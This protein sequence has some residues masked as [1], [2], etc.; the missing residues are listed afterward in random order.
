[1]IFEKKENIGEAT[2]CIPHYLAGETDMENLFSRPI[3]KT[4]SWYNLKINTSHLVETIRPD[5]KEIKVRDLKNDKVVVEKYGNLIIATG[6][7]ARSISSD[8]ENF[9]KVSNI[10]VISDV[11][12]AKKLKEKLVGEEKLK[13]AIIGAGNIGLETC[14]ALLKLDNSHISIIDKRNQVCSCLDKDMSAYIEKELESQGVSLYLNREVVKFSPD[15]KKL[16]LDNKN[17]ISFDILVIS[18]G[19]MPNVKLAKD[20][21]IKLGKTGG[22]KVNKKFETSIRNIYAVGDVIENFSFIN[23][24]KLLNRNALTSVSNSRTLANILGG[25]KDKNKGTLNIGGSRFARVQYGWV[26]LREKDLRWGYETIRFH[27]S[28]NTD[29]VP[30]DKKLHV[31]VLFNRRKKKILGAQAVGNLGV[32]KFLDV[33][34]GVIVSKN[35]ILNL[36]NLEQCY[37]PEYNTVKPLITKIGYQAENI[38]LK[39]DKRK[40]LENLDEEFAKKHTVLDVRDEEEHRKFDIPETKNIPLGKIRGEI[41]KIKEL[42]QPIYILCGSGHRAFIAE[43]ILRANDIETIVIDGGIQSIKIANYKKGK[44]NK[45]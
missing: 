17:E 30:G 25:I 32:D 29:C 11:S 6:S 45:E 22:I 13:I 28:A 27:S 44:E 24:K 16:F 5:V 9:D 26:G 33:I 4:K 2:C 42:K 39:L 3:E 1:M 40:Y 31:K 21:G 19:H 41:E 20:I 23:K 37:T 15:G 38:I 12:S 10:H 36:K 35:N 18:M 8:L 43:R 34:A 14:D 7:C